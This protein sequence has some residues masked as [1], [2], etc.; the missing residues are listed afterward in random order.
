MEGVNIMPRP[1]KCR[2]I[3]Y[4][5]KHKYFKPS[6]VDAVEEY[7]LKYE[8]LEAMRLKDIEKL[9]QEQAAKLMQVSRQ[10]FQNIIESARYKVALALVEGKAIRIEGG[11]YKI[12]ECRIQ[13]LHCGKEYRLE[14][15]RDRQSCPMCAS[16]KIQCKS[17]KQ[18]CKIAEQ[19]Q[20]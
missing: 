17:K 19:E 20:A 7:Q 12:K 18:C 3:S 2:K 5:P 13:C 15:M 16:K 11:N 9:S 6:E 1:T 4:V 10:T 8:E 14:Y